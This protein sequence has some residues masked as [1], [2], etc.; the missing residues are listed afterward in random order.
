MPDD[1]DAIYFGSPT[2]WR[3]WLEVNHATAD[4]VWL[5]YWKKH[6]GRV[7][8][9]WSE[10]VDQA[11]CFG[12]I[13]SVRQSVDE[14]RS[15]QRFTPRRRGSTWSNVN[16]EKVAQLEA[17]GLMTDAGRAVFEARTLEGVYSYENGEVE[18]SPEYAAL[19]AAS[20]AALEFF[21]A[22]RASYRKVAKRWV[23]SARQ[24][25]TR[26][27]RMA[28]LVA[29]CEAGLLIRPQRYGQSPGSG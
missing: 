24:Q 19:L 4:F 13:D 29:D 10:A 21:E 25:Q 16:V 5:G 26:D 7:N 17:L 12:W 6:T 20:P 15:R 22:Q 14:D 9:T 23:M 28:Q 18:L 27:R 2:A 8:L 3:S 1:R 11:L